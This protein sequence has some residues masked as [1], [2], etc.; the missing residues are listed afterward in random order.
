MA[1]HGSSHSIDSTQLAEHAEAI[2]VHIKR[3]V[4][5][6]VDIGRRLT[7]CKVIAGRGN[8]LVW[9]DREFG[10]SEDTAER[11][12]QAH[13]VF[14]SNSARV[15]NLP[16]LPLRSFYLLTAKSTP[17]VAREEVIGRAAGGERLSHDQVK[18]AIAGHKPLPPDAEIFAAVNA[19][20]RTMF[21]AM[22]EAVAD[23]LRMMKEG[24]TLAEA[25]PAAMDAMAAEEDGLSAHL[26]EAIR[27][28]RA[29]QDAPALHHDYGAVREATKVCF[30]AREIAGEILQR[31]REAAEAPAMA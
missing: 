28:Y 29:F 20:L 25:S 17:E 22:K 27:Q 6:V 14:G 31:V 13:R 16:D 10:W 23:A 19:N 1:D 21:D 8:W 18:A 2:R 4:A 12:M 3:V 5:D 26:C 11:Y 9:L 7:E 30:L 15:R 24:K